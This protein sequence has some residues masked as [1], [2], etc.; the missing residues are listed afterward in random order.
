MQRLKQQVAERAAAVRPQSAGAASLGAAKLEERGRVR[1]RRV[2][3]FVGGLAAVPRAVG[4]LVLHLVVE[5][6]AVVGRREQRVGV[7]GVRLAREHPRDVLI[8]VRVVRERA[9]DGGIL[10]GDEL[11]GARLQAKLELVA[12]RLGERAVGRRR[13]GPV[14][15][16]LLAVEARVRRHVEALKLEGA[17]VDPVL[18]RLHD[19]VRRVHPDPPEVG[20][21]VDAVPV[22]LLL[23]RQRRAGL[24]DG[25]RRQ[26]RGVLVEDG[27][28]VAGVVYP[29]H[30]KARRH[31][32]RV[33]LRVPIGPDVPR[34]AHVPPRRRRRRRK[35][36][37][38]RRVG[39]EGDRGV[40]LAVGGVLVVE[41]SSGRRGS[42]RRTPWHL[43]LDR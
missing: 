12:P 1:R 2:E 15:H 37:K 4:V 32:L 16:D 19:D 22:R 25:R 33:L 17:H 30:C 21:R 24:G 26:Q 11:L 7:I 36:R 10:R 8:E 35:G 29:E 14:F 40:G 9:E 31:E 38:G 5:R 27:H 28:R 42:G 23:R 6:P 43:R 20:Q 18:D 3:G 34:E 39:V 41:P 13:H